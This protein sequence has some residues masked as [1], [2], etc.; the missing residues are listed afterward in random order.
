MENRVI[1]FRAWNKRKSAM[2][3]S[4]NEIH[5][6]GSW[7][8]AHLPGS[9]ADVDN[10]VIMQFTGLSDKNGNDI[11]E[12][13]IMSYTSSLNGRTYFGRVIYTGGLFALSQR[14]PNGISDEIEYLFTRT[15]Y[16]IIGNVFDNPKLIK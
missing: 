6:L 16:E 4:P 5:H 1:K 9:L 12:G 15:H 10:I 14:Y 2:Y 7:F 8:D 13:D 11:Y 3:L